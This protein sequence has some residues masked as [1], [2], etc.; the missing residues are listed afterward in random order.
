[1]HDP[2]RVQFRQELLLFWDTIAGA[3]DG[4][5]TSDEVLRGQSVIRNRACE[6]L[7]IPPRRSNVFVAQAGDSSSLLF[8]LSQRSTM[9]SDGF[10]PRA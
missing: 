2:E 3:P 8:P 10:S 9:H 4:R 6:F 1:V 5:A 7:R